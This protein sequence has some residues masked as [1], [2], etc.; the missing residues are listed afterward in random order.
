MRRDEDAAGDQGDVTHLIVAAAVVS[1]SADERSLFELFI[2]L[3]VCEVQKKNEDKTVKVIR[4]GKS[5]E[6]SNW[7]VLVGDILHLEAGDL[8]PADGIFISGHN[9]TCDELG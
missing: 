1:E 2:N 4:S 5:Q 6:I 7:D 9:V 8:V 3:D